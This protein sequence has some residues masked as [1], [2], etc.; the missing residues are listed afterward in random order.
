MCRGIEQ[1]LVIMLTVQ[2]NERR[3]QVAKRRAGDERPVNRR[4]AASL[5]GDLAPDDD[6]GASRSLEDS[7][8]GGRL[9]TGADEFSRG[10]PSDEQ[11]NGAHE[12]GFSRSSLPRENVQ[13]GLELN[14]QAVD[15]GQVADGKETQHGTRSTILSDV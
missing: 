13:A 11:S 14:L 15:D 3:A 4:A 6:V 10:T 2:I 7:L 8:H 9:F 12:N 5:R 1:Q